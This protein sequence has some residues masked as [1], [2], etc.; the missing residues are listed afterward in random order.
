MSNSGEFSG[1][2][3]LVTGGARGIGRA[4]CRIL[5]Q[6]GARIVVNYRNS[7]VEA[8]ATVADC[9]AAG[10]DAIAV[11]ADVAVAQQVEQLVKQA[12][13]H[14]RTIDLLVNNAGIFEMTPHD[15]MPFDHW[16]RTMDCNLT[17]AYLVTWAVKDEMVARGDG[18]IVNVSSIAGLRSRPTAIAYSVSKAGMIALT[19]SLSDAIS[20]VGIRVNSVAPGLIDTDILDGVDQEVID[21]LVNVTPMRRLGTPE[22]IAEVVRFLLSDQ[23]RFMS[24]QTVVASGGRVLLP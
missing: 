11:Q 16:Q 1:K 3:A 21:G 18:R 6:H 4:C 9:Q 19:R 14:F 23:S 22:D 12:R 20:G 10:A 13:S 5:A 15:Q 8:E 7:R 17:S 24:G 2:T